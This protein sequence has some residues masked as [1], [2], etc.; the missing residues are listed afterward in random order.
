MKSRFGLWTSK[1]S[2]ISV[3]PTFTACITIS[4]RKSDILVCKYPRL[5]KLSNYFDVLMKY[6]FL[7]DKKTS[8]L[9]FLTFSLSYFFFFFFFSSF[10]FTLYLIYNLRYITDT[11][12]HFKS[13]IAK[14]YPVTHVTDIQYLK[15]S[16]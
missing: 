5:I 1:S 7:L 15:L 12:M 4:F 11:K 14:L 3:S 9:F 6:L 16:S 8:Y 2:S 13:D 10:Q